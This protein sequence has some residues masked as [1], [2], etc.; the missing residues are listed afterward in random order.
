MSKKIAVLADTSIGFCKLL[1]ALAVLT[2]CALLMP[3][4]AAHGQPADD[5]APKQIGSSGNWTAY[6]MQEGKAQICYAVTQPSHVAVNEILIR[7]TEQ[8]Q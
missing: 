3:L 8:E 5:A 1:M 7:P 6:T 2:L 4:R